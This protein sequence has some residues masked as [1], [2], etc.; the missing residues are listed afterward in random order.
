MKNKTVSKSG[1]INPY[2]FSLLSKPMKVT[3][4]KNKIQK[5]GNKPKMKLFVL[6][7]S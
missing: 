7:S 4:E 1:L 3:L 2:Y 5:Q 6:S